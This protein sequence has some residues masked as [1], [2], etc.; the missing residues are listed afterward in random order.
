MQFNKQDILKTVLIVWL[1][2]STAY[3][4]YDIYDNF[5]IKSAQAAYQQGYV[6]SAREVIEKVSEANCV[7]IEIRTGDESVAVVAG[8]CGI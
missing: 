5:R 1:M 7:P 3:V 8:T 4:V 2:A 6:D